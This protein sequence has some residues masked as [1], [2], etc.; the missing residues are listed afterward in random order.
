MKTEIYIATHKAYEFPDVDG[1]IPIHVGKVL[2]DVDLGIIGD[3]T[4]ENISEINPN[5]CELT[6]L[7]WMWKNSDADI[8]GLV[9]YRRYMK[10]SFIENNIISNK[11]E[12]LKIDYIEDVIINNEKTIF[13]P[14]MEKLICQ[15]YKIK[16]SV[17][18]KEQF[19]SNH[20]KSD[21][22]EIENIIESKFPEYL[23]SFKKAEKQTKISFYNMF[24]AHR[25]IVNAY[26]EWLF[27]ILFELRGRLDIS[28][29]DSYQARVYGF[30]SERLLNV[31]IYHHR[32]IYNIKNLD[33]F[34]AE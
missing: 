18:M 15:K 29:Y 3:N 16:F 26:C 2:T 12:I 8:L 13:L 21:W 17:D 32:K 14:K 4:G 9:H 28:C 10:D 5:F 7:Y 22:L 34:F 30:I 11:W 20:Y 27:D 19:E 31:Y 6:A 25:D 23:S 1:Y 24:I 33:I